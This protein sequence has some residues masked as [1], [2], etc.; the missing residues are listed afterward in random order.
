MNITARWLGNMDFEAYNERNHKVSMSNM[1]GTIGPTPMELV[2]MGVGGCTGLDVVS[3]L[4]K[5]RVSFDR[6]EIQVSGER[7][8]DHPKVF[9]QVSV[10]YRVW[11]QDIPEDKVAR[12]VQLTQE[13][14]CSVLH[15]V[16]K[17]AEVSYRYEINPQA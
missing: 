1:E 3:I 2:L 11:G 10:V 4:Q 17:T 6:F 15:M 8:E 16:N 7:A 12:A 5:M 14:Y 9:K 13:K